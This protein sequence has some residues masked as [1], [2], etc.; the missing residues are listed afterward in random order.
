M[1]MLLKKVL[2]LSIALCLM[3]GCLKRPGPRTGDFN[4]LV[5]DSLTEQPIPGVSINIGEQ[6]IETDPNGQFSLAGLAPGDYQI[7]M[8]RQWYKSKE[9][10]YKHLGKPE[11]VI[12]YLRPIGL[13][14][15]IYYSYDEGDNK[16]IYELLLE[17]RSVRKVLSL[18]DSSETNPACS[19]SGK[20]AVEST[21]NK[22]S[23]VI[24]Y[25][26]G[27]GNPTPILIQDGEHPSIDNKGKYVVF[28]SNGKIVKYDVDSNQEIESYDQAGWNPVISPDGTRVAYVS[29]NYDKLYIYSSKTECDVFVPNGEYD[30]YKLN[31]PCWSPDGKKIAFEAYEKSEGK[32]AIYYIIVDSLDS[33]MIPITVPLGDKEQHKHPTWGEDDMIYFSGN[34]LYSSRSDIYGVSLDHGS[35]WVMVSKGPGNKLYPCWGK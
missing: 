26:F 22:I 1:E 14:G 27:N 13:P 10:T 17:N 6:S 12:F 33:G 18:Q 9:V 15:R 29:G 25:D 24:V 19:I 20:F 31:N 2:T 35:I 30:G 23:K 32:R 21:I 8:S 4:A 34:I 7:R 11:P 3:T 5:K 16:E 28:K